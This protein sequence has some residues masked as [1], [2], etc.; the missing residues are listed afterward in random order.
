MNQTIIWA[1]V[2]I[3]QH[4]KTFTEIMEDVGK[5]NAGINLLEDVSEH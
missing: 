3:F 5:E 4:G 2:L 1:R